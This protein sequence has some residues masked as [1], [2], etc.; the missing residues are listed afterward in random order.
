MYPPVVCVVWGLGYNVNT[1][2]VNLT[3]RIRVP[4]FMRVPHCPRYFGDDDR[5]HVELMVLNPKSGARVLQDVGSV[6]YLPGFNW[7][8]AQQ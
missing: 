2:I 8:Q 4:A 1:L 6:L 5:P 7:Y 3:T